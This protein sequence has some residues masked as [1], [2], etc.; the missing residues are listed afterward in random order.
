MESDEDSE[1]ELDFHYVSPQVLQPNYL[2]E[3][4]KREPLLASEH[5]EH[6]YEVL[7][8]VS[9]SM[10][11]VESDQ[12]EQEL[13]W[14]TDSAEKEF[15]LPA[16]EQF[17]ALM[18]PAESDQESQKEQTCLLPKRDRCPPRILTYDE[19][20]RPSY[21]VRQLNGVLQTSQLNLPYMPAQCLSTG[22]PP[23]QKYCYQFPFVYGVH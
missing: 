7:E 20:G 19:L 9:E 18:S 16:V 15:N 23:I 21:N 2:V 17:P 10:S 14:G 13:P 8:Q 6:P 12:V 3:S 11:S 5:G 22:L 1:D 4:E